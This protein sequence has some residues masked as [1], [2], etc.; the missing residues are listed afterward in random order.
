[1]RH[2]G[3]WAS[4]RLSSGESSCRS[5]K[6]EKGQEIKILK[7]H[8][9]SSLQRIR[10]VC[11]SYVIVPCPVSLTPCP[12]S[13]APCSIFHAPHLMFHTPCSMPA[14]ENEPKRDSRAEASPIRRR[15][16][17]IEMT[18]SHLSPLT[19]PS[20]PFFPPTPHPSF[21]CCLSVRVYVCVCSP[22]E[23]SRGF[24]GAFWAAWLAGLFWLGGLL[25]SLIA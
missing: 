14:F 21:S 20:A 2:A 25:G 6:T 17:T 9:L 12:T 13:L 23:T 19:I 15:T 10:M 11:G 18:P 16:G 3:D 8:R 5:T 24:I 7:H 1:M 22:L 4:R